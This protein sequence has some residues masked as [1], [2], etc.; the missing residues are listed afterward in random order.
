M[1]KI[2]ANSLMNSHLGARISKLN[3]NKS[4]VLNLKVRMHPMTEMIIKTK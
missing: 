2:L 1:N 4:T 3:N